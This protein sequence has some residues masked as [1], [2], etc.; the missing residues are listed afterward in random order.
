MAKSLVKA[1]AS[2][3]RR[4]MLEA[5]RDKLADTIE[6]TESGRDV[7]AL[8]R[9]LMDVCAEL[10][11]LPDDSEDANPLQRARAIYGGS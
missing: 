7:A 10:D 2:G 1:A 9:R 8:A 5:L 6:N 11:A 4:V 3:D